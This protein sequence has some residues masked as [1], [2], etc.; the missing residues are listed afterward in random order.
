MLKKARFGA[1]KTAKKFLNYSKG[2]KDYGSES[3]R[4]NQ[5]E[6]LDAW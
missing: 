2:L 3:K 1:S 5:Q 4:W 6:W